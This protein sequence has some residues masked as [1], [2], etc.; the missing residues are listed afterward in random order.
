MDLSM[1]L[2]I[3]IVGLIWFG[4]IIL[5]LVATTRLTRFGWQFHGHQIVAEVKMWSA[6]LYVDGNLEDEFA[7]ERM[8][9]CTLRAFLD[10]VQVKVRVTHGF[11][12]KA[13]ATANGEQLSVI[14]VGK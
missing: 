1:Y 10:G 2:G 11:R 9:V 3:G 14:F 13:E 12:A 7:A 4:V 8:R 5:I 6:K